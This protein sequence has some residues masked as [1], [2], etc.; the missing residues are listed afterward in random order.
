MVNRADS[1]VS[2]LLT[3]RLRNTAAHASWSLI[4]WNVLLSSLHNPIIYVLNKI[5][6]KPSMSLSHN[7]QCL[8]RKSIS[9]CLPFNFELY[10]IRYS[11]TSRMMHVIIGA[12]KH[13]AQVGSSRGT[14]RRQRPRR[15]LRTASLTSCHSC[16]SSSF[17]FLASLHSSQSPNCST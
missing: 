5:I 4:Q 6:F 15:G 9:S 12:K 13:P 1:L 10:G 7:L 3:D 2:T 17:S 11:Q 8:V 14:R 16:H